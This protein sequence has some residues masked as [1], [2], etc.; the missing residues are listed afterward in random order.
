MFHAAAVSV[1]VGAAVGAAVGTVVST[2]VCAAVGAGVGVNSKAVPMAATEKS[3]DAPFHLIVLSKL[4][5]GMREK[6]CGQFLKM[7]KD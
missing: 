5:I 4:E 2:A 3:M 1:A 7:R 6:I